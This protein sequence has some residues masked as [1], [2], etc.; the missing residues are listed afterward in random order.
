M[1]HIIMKLK[2]SRIHLHESDLIR[3]SVEPNFVEILK[4]IDEQVHKNGNWFE[5]RILTD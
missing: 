1:Q 4:K 2:H 3:P 5:R